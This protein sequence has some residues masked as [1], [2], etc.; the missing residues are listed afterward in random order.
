M[1]SLSPV[2]WS[3]GMHLAP[4]H[5]QAQ[6]RY[7]QD[8]INFASSAIWMENYGL[9]A[10]ELSDEALENGQLVLIHARG[11]FPDGLV[12]HMPG[13]DEPPPPRSIAERFSPTEN[14]LTVYLAVPPTRPEGLNYALNPESAADA[15]FVAESRNLADETTGRD[16]KPI[17]LGRK[18]IRFVFENEPAGDMVRLP[19]ARV[20]RSGSG[21]FIYD[22]RFVPPCLDITASPRLMSMLQ[23]LL[24]I[25]QDRSQSLALGSEEHAAFSLQELTRFWFLHTINAGLAPLRH[26]FYTR[27]GHPEHLFIELSR[28][29][30]AL[31]TFALDAHPRSLPSYDHM[32]PES[33]FD[34]LDMHIRRHLEIV[35][36]TSCL[37]IALQSEGDYLFWGDVT[38]QRCLGPSTW[39]LALRGG[40]GDANIMGK[41]P[42]LV[43]VC[44]RSFV[45]QLVKRALPGFELNHLP[46][47]PPAVPVRPG[48]Q[49]FLISKAGPCWEHIIKTR[50][51]GVYIPGEFPN[52]EAELLVVI[53]PK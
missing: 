24:G 10:S 2:V 44:S 48:T 19:I 15:R 35:I 8:S 40:G 46:T 25:L 3:E 20:M 4:Q 17:R 50:Q 1:K 30:G 5:F 12:F 41:V 31:C 16:E 47:P 36:P 26:L 39:I 27:R 29:A 49:Y 11:V 7:V 28:L 32:Q 38:D 21:R 13:S 14:R 6:S 53:E 43:K 18:N 9:V 33:C 34:A 22:P 52:P 51:A 42:G 23:H 37:R 45:P